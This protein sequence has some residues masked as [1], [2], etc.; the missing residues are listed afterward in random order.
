[1]LPLVGALQRLFDHFEVVI[2]LLS[3]AIAFDL[4]VV[5]ERFSAA[6]KPLCFLAELQSV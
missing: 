4:E 3:E 6:C 5:V 1:M 2:G